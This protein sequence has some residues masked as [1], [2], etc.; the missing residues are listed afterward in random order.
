MENCPAQPDVRDLKV[1]LWFLPTSTS[2]TKQLGQEVWKKVCNGIEE[3]DQNIK[4]LMDFSFFVFFEEFE[5]MH[6]SEVKILVA[7]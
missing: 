5:E 1:G 3:H 6:F 4:R 7:L 2:I